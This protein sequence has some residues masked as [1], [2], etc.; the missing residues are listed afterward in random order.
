MDQARKTGDPRT[1]ERWLAEIDARNTDN[2]AR[3]NSYLELYD[4]TCDHP[5]DLPWVLMAHLVSR[6]AGYLMTDLARR[7]ARESGRTDQPGFPEAATNLFLLLERANFLIFHDAWYH[8]LSHLLGRTDSAPE[9]RTTQFVIGAWRRYVDALNEEGTDGKPSPALE[10]A[11]V[12][13]LV[14]NEQNFIERRAVHHERFGPARALIGLIESSG[15][16]KPIHLPLTEAEIRVGSFVDLEHRIAAGRRI[17]D[18]VLADRDRREA[19]RTW[20][21][22]HPHD[23]SR[24]VYGGRPGPPLREAWPVARVRAMWAGIHAPPEPDPEFP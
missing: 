13:D 21:Q 23:G 11:L 16:E 6:N 4:Y 8:V 14:E 17:Y 15:R 12:F 24:A 3:T 7:L 18:E 2:V 10:R 22:Q 5:P 1:L 9:G 20:A 19:L